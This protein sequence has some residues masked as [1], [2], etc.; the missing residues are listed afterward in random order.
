MAKR[1]LSTFDRLRM[2]QMPRNRR[3]RREIERRLNA[4]DPGLEIVYPDAAGIDVG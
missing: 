4:A 3:E 2:G 1:K